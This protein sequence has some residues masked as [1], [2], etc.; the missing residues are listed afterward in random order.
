HVQTI[1]DPA[2][3]QTL[4]HGVGFI[5]AGMGSSD[6]DRVEGLFKDGVI[7]VCWLLQMHLR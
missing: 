3:Q 6:R 2:L 7:K 4:A 1:R 5:H